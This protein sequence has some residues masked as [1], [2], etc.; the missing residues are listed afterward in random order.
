MGCK[1]GGGEHRGHIGLEIEE[2]TEAVLHWEISSFRKMF[3]PLLSMINPSSSA[4]LWRLLIYLLTEQLSAVSLHGLSVVNC[5]VNSALQNWNSRCWLPSGRHPG[6]KACKIRAV[7]ALSWSWALWSQG[8]EDVPAWGFRA[9]GVAWVSL[10]PG[11]CYRCSGKVR[12]MLALWVGC[13][14]A[15][16]PTVT[17]QDLFLLQVSTKHRPAR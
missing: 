13:V 12:C 5:L 14:L 1:Q 4:S 10:E 3:A 9:A 15:A 17:T 7:K 16:F 8:S 2:C 11:G 6:I